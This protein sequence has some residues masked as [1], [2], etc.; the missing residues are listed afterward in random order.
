MSRNYTGDVRNALEH[1]SKSTKECDGHAV[2]V[3]FWLGSAV[4]WALLEIAMAV[5]ELSIQVRNR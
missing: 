5:R 4:V 1:A 3:A 2:N